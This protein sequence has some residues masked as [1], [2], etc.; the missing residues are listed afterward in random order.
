MRV[1]RIGVVSDTHN[2]LRNVERIVELLR[3][4]A[5]EQVVHT[6]DITQPRALRALAR[7]GVPIVGVFGNNDER[8]ALR[9]GSAGLRIELAEP[10][11]EWVLASRR[12]L[13][14][15]DPTE[16]EG[17]VEEEHALVLH[18]HTHRRTIERS[19]GR[20]LFNPGECAGHAAGRQTVGVVDLVT[21]EPELLHF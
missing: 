10:P 7:V 17:A 21:L 19:P 9:E 15:H 20:L 8:G 18:G 6:G 1:M 11:F 3:A 13:V 5:V 12:V 14:A 16:L 4:A 2:N